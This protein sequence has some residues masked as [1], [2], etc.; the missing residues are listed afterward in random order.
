MG[1]G[2]WPGR[3]RKN[4]CGVAFPGILRVYH[5]GNPI[6][7][8]PE[9][10]IHVRTGILS[11]LV[12]LGLLALGCS[13][14]DPP[15]SPPETDF[16]DVFEIALPALAGDYGFGGTIPPFPP[17]HRDVTFRFPP[18][19]ESFRRLR[20]VVSGNWNPGTIET[21][22]RYPSGDSTIVMTDTTS[23]HVN[24]V[25]ALVPADDPGQ[26]FEAAVVPAAGGYQG[27]DEFGFY[28]DAD[29]LVDDLLLGSEIAA[30]LQCRREI[31]DDQV[32]LVPAVGT[33]TGIRLE[34]LGAVV[35]R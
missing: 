10:G 26:L 27:D 12:L 2:H 22:R 13:S 11:L 8:G 24:L 35:V 15:A 20:F 14:S 29:C 32:I 34:A 3:I 28:C 25:L 30:E 5:D 19:M 31:G 1:H 21:T 33:V 23:L 18:N 16:H 7:L 9:K 4:P 6:P 17:S